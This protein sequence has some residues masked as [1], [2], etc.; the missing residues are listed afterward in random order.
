MRIEFS[1]PP[2]QALRRRMALACIT[3]RPA[4]VLTTGIVSALA[5]VVIAFVHGRS[6]ADGSELGELP[7]TAAAVGFLLYGLVLIRVV[8]A[9]PRRVAARSLEADL[10]IRFVMDDDGI[11]TASSLRTQRIAW[12]AADRAVTTA[13]F[14]VLMR[15]RRPLFVIPR[16]FILPAQVAEA[17]G[18]LQAKNLLPVPAPIG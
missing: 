16:Q 18:L 15:H 10:P 9:I 2:D 11:E 1:I 3:R 17:N 12:A 6:A 4:A 7:L 13:E 8:T 5:G 14:W